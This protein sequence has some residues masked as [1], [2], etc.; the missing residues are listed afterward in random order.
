MDEVGE[1]AARLTAFY[2]E[3]NTAMLKTVGEVSLCHDI[4]SFFYFCSISSTT[5]RLLAESKMNITTMSLRNDIH[6]FYL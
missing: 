6:S 5:L 3:H 1:L 2:F 4:H